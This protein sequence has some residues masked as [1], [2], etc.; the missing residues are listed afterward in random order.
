M[1]DYPIITGSP[2]VSECDPIKIKLSADLSEIHKCE[3]CKQDCI[4]S[5]TFMARTKAL[6]HES[7]RRLILLCC[8]CQD[9]IMAQ[10]QSSGIPAYVANIQTPETATLEKRYAG[11]N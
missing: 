4:C 11:M 7:G 10:A 8:A 3:Q 6:S 2:L 1:A 9:L 5:K